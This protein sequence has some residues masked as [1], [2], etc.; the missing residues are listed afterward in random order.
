MLSDPV[1][2]DAGRVGERVH[3]LVGERVEQQVDVGGQ[4]ARVAALALAVFELLEKGSEV[5]VALEIRPSGMVG[6]RVHDLVCLQPA[7][8]ASLVQTEV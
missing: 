3:H 6:R 2:V 7:E 5:G 4:R 1:A 8:D